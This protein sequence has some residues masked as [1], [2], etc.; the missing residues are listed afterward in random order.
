MHIAI[1]LYGYW[2]LDSSVGLWRAPHSKHQLKK[3]SFVRDTYQYFIDSIYMPLKTMYG[4]VDIY[5]IAFEFAHPKYKQLKEELIETCK[6]FTIFFT[7]QHE[8]PKLPYTYWNLIRHASSIKKYDRYIIT[9][10]DLFYKAKITEWMPPYNPGK[11]ACWFLFKDY[12]KTWEENNIISDI[13]FIV[14]NN[15]EKFKKCV[16]THI[17]RYPERTELHGIYH[18]LKENF[19]ENVDCIAEGYYDS[20]SGK[21]VLESNNPIYIMVNRPYFFDLNGNMKSTNQQFNI[22]KPQIQ[23]MNGNAMPKFNRKINLGETNTPD[24]II[25]KKVHIIPKAISSK[26]VSEQQKEINNKMEKEKQQKEFLSKV[27]PQKMNVEIRQNNNNKVR[28]VGL[29]K[30]RTNR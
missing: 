27:V 13:I 12:K 19:G 11:D 6:N 3:Y 29:G 7:N 2:Y 24:K 21:Q 1:L 22:F 16:Q 23:T 10:G 4:S 9:R 28:V 17:D 30:M 26:N 15:I 20:N 8:S 18:I 5:M 14:D 25:P